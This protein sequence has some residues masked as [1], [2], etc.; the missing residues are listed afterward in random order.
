MA[1][2]SRSRSPRKSRSACPYGKV[3]RKGH[4]R[5]SPSGKRIRVPGKC[6]KS[7]R[8]SPARR[9][10]RSRSPRRS[11]STSKVRIHVRKGTLS[12]YG[13][14]SHLSTAERHHALELAA[15][16]E[17]WLPIFRKLNVLM[18]FNR[19]NNP[20]LSRLF[21]SDKRWVKANFS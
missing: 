6:V 2:R 10:Q 12:K 13:Y 21:E 11:R 9:R 7:P 20:Q 16:N 18:I 19:N 15:E 3:Y 4:T 14:S 5:R 1:R 8:K 17:G